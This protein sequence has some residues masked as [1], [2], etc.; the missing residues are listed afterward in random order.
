MDK[1]LL[2]IFATL[3]FTG[4]AS[5]PH[6]Y[7]SPNH[8]PVVQD[9]KVNE[10]V[11]H[12]EMAHEKF[13]FQ[14]KGAIEFDFR[15]VFRDKER[16]NAHFTL[17]TNET[18]GRIDQTD[19]TS[20]VYDGMESWVIS[21]SIS[22]DEKRF[23]I[24]TWSYFFL[25]PYKLSDPGTVYSDFPSD[26]LNGVA[27]HTQKLT[28]APGTGDAP[29]DWYILYADEQTNLLEVAAYIVTAN[30]SVE[31]AEEDPHAIKYE[32]YELVDGV[33]ISTKWT[34]WSWREN[35]GLTE[36]LGYAELTNFRFS[37]P[38]KADFV[39]P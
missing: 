2:L 14:S 36:Q 10:F 18:K 9:R 26:S 30:K 25:L 24:Y 28:F 13:D 37:S 11:M 34:F 19:G 8:V 20:M 15:L 23:D 22:K 21:D 27:Y 38:R 1:F 16:M 39:R 4:C 35:L 31:K 6:E 29:D 7:S 5:E 33:P 17:L 3:I 12:T 32:A